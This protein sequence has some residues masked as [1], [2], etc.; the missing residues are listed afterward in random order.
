MGEVTIVE[1]VATAAGR[2]E[3]GAPKSDFAK[4]M[5]QEMS[6]AIMKAHADGM[7]NDPDVIKA[8][9]E[10]ARVEVKKQYGIS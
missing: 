7:A 4:I 2:N 5:E 10:T 9:I 8:R 6:F 1:A 3:A